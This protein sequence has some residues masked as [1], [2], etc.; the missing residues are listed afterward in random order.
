[1]RKNTQN[2]PSND[3]PDASLECTLHGGANV[4]LE[5]TS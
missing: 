3:G 1:M 4:A 2:N 5:G